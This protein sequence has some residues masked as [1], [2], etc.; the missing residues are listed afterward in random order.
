MAEVNP[1]ITDYH[2]S[3]DGFGTHSIPAVSV[4]PPGSK[5]ATNTNITCTYSYPVRSLNLPR[6]RIGGHVAARNQIGTGRKCSPLQN[7]IGNI[8]WF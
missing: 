7:G 6:E 1:N 8:M 2:I 5:S 3:V 4:C